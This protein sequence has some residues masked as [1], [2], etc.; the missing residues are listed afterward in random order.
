MSNAERIKEMLRKAYTAIYSVLIVYM[1]LAQMLVYV[2]NL[3][4][5]A[6]SGRMMIL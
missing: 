2:K 6:L 4:Q 3:L 1:K 5:N